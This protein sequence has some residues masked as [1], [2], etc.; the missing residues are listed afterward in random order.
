[1]H[2]IEMPFSSPLLS[3]WSLLQPFWIFH[4]TPTQCFAP[5]N[6]CLT[7]P[8]ICILPQV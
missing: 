5:L 4:L 3:S 2:P 1:M 8:K 7:L 6:I